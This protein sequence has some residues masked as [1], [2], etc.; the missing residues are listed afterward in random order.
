[1]NGEEP[2]P[3]EL[4]LRLRRLFGGLDAGAGF[5][6]R[7]MQRVATHAAAP[8]GN[9][10]AQF[11]RRRELVRRRLRREAWMNGITAL[12]MAAC[13]AALLRHFVPEIQRLAT[14]T[15]L[16]VDPVV[17][18]AGTVA[19]VGAAVWLLVRPARG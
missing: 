18:A 1:M 16:Q 9:L 12:G 4:D 7:V 5:E 11:E 2:R 15:V 13:A 3:A 19:A 6:S 17:L 8:Q 14:H 10:R